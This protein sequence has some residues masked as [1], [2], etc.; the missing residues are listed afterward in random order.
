MKD[1][2]TSDVLYHYTDQHGLVGIIE[3]RELRATSLGCLNDLSEF[4][5]GLAFLRSSRDEIVGY[6]LRDRPRDVPETTN[7]ERVFEAMMDRAEEIIGVRDPSEYLFAFSL[8]GSGHQPDAGAPESDPGDNL[9][10]WR[11]YSKGGSGY[12]IGFDRKL[13]EIKAEDANYAMQRTFCGKCA[14]DDAGKR[15]IARRIIGTLVPAFDLAV[16]LGYPQ[17]QAGREALDRG[18]GILGPELRKM[19]AAAGAPQPVESEPCQGPSPSKRV[20]CFLEN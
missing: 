11:A 3:H 8:F 19:R 10:Q 2:R 14:Y 1:E 13:L 9:Q 20:S 16:F 18:I 4:K 17:T 12:C 15:E 5:H 6:L 7:P